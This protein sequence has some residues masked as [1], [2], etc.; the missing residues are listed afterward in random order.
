MNLFD[1]GS[2]NWYCFTA[3]QHVFLTLD[4]F[5]KKRKKEIKIKLIQNSLHYWF[6]AVLRSCHDDYSLLLCVRWWKG[7]W[8][9]QIYLFNS[10]V[11]QITYRNVPAGKTELPENA[12]KPESISSVWEA[13]RIHRCLWIL[14]CFLSRIVLFTKSMSLLLDNS[15]NLSFWKNKRF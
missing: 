2:I 15:L 10:L 11:Q 8:M 9:W 14:L 12:N 13:I 4:E 5:Q 3:S 1:C 7:W 6:K